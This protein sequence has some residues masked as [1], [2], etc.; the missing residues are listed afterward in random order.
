MLV[1][2]PNRA[3]SFIIRCS[4]TSTDIE[5]KNKFPLDF[6]CQFFDILRTYVYIYNRPY[7]TIHPLRSFTN[8]P[9]ASPPADCYLLTTDHVAHAR[10]VARRLTFAPSTPHYGSTFLQ[11]YYP[12]ALAWPPEPPHLGYTMHRHNFEHLPQHTKS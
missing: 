2:A 8:H 12:L 11:T 6:T 7:Y 10:P 9:R 5:I 4:K 3:N 1:P